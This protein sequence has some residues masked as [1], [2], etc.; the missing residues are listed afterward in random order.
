MRTHP[1]IISSWYQEG[2]PWAVPWH[3]S[4]PFPVLLPAPKMPA[5]FF[6]YTRIT[7]HIITIPSVNQAPEMGHTLG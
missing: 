3:T 1:K 2:I 5:Q 4:W 6:S 7:K